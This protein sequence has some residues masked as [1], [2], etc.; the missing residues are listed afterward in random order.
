M[1]NM[2]KSQSTK[3]VQ[4][5]KSDEK[6]EST[7]DKQN[8]DKKSE[9][10]HD[11]I[12]PAFR[13]KPENRSNR[14]VIRYVGSIAKTDKLC[15][16]LVELDKPLHP[17]PDVFGKN[18]IPIKKIGDY[19]MFGNIYQSNIIG[20]YIVLGT[21][22]PLIYLNVEYRR[23]V[24]TG[25]IFQLVIAIDM[26]KDEKKAI[27]DNKKYVNL[28]FTG[29]WAQYIDADEELVKMYEPM[30]DKM[31]EDEGSK[32]FYSE[33]GDKIL[34]NKED[35]N[36]D[37]IAEWI[38]KWIANEKKF[39]TD[40]VK[41][42]PF[43]FKS[44]NSAKKYLIDICQSEKF[45]KLLCIA[46]KCREIHRKRERNIEDDSEYQIPKYITNLSDIKKQLLANNELID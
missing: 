37:E 14:C 45:Y 44:M 18:S 20:S 31:L 30:I 35:M 38:E 26:N 13:L 36:E 25:S 43:E 10:K 22:Y 27:K 32:L 33:E 39:Y 9:K 19:D 11:N 24:V 7:N 16:E 23:T 29:T 46:M 41:G 21:R 28:S 34:P 6:A 17:E 4:S 1:Q 8:P 40:I 15:D 3:T 42:C 12:V 5:T 2:E